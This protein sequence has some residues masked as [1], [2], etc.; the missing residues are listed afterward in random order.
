[1]TELLLRHGAK[2]VDN[3]SRRHELFGRVE[4]T[5]AIVDRQR[6][7]QQQV[8]AVEAE[9]TTMRHNVHLLN[10]RGQKIEDMGDK[11]RELNNNAAEF[12]S[13]ASQLKAQMKQK[14]GRWG[15]F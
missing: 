11:A 10:E 8:A 4:A 6:L 9:N 15:L 5:Q 1:M 12:K 3:D 14:S 7:L 2:K 13:L